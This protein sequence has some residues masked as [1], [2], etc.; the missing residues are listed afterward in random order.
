MKKISRLIVFFSIL[1][2]IGFACRGSSSLQEDADLPV[3]IEDIPLVDLADIPLGEWKVTEL[4]GSITDERTGGG[5]DILCDYY[6]ETYQAILDS[7]DNYIEL[8][9]MAAAADVSDVPEG[10]VDINYLEGIEGV[11][12]FSFSFDNGYFTNRGVTALPSQVVYFELI[13]Q[14]WTFDLGYWG[15]GEI[16]AKNHNGSPGGGINYFVV[17]GGFGSAEAISGTWT[18]FEKTALPEG[19]APECESTA[20]GKGTWAAKGP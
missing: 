15:A 11:F 9:M 3:N 5:L 19:V 7:E 13:P 20:K 14:V 17:E 8:M 6:K 4:T 2:S 18:Y 12:A 10:L 16:F 1:T